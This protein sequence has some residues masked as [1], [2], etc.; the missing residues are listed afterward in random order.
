MNGRRIPV[1]WL[2]TGL[3][4]PAEGTGRE[5]ASQVNELPGGRRGQRQEPPGQWLSSPPVGQGYLTVDIQCPGMDG[6]GRAR[7][8]LG[9]QLCPIPNKLSRS[10]QIPDVVFAAQITSASQL[11]RNL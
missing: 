6:P 10:E 11:F 3:P 8:C 7:T 1:V 5:C 9:T 2:P 4:W